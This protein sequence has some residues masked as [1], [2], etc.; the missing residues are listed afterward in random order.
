MALIGKNTDA[1]ALGPK[2][3]TKNS[4][5]REGYAALAA[6]LTR[7]QAELQIGASTD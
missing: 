4:R 3:D 1:D 5:R 6:F 7:P 2:P